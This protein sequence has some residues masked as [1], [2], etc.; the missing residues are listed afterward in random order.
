M[1]LNERQGDILRWIGEGTPERE[2]PDWSHRTTAKAL[3]SRGLVKVR[4]YGP[5]WTATVTDRGRRVLSGEVEVPARGARTATRKNKTTSKS[6]RNATPAGPAQRE[7]L[8]PEDLVADLLIAAD[9][10]LHVPD[11][12]D[13]TRAAYRRALAGIPADLVQTGKRVTYT[14]RNRGDL[15]ISPVDVPNPLPPDPAVVVPS[16]S[17][18]DDL[19]ARREVGVQRQAGA[20]DPRALGHTGLG[21]PQTLDAGIPSP[22]VRPNDREGDPAE[23]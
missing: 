4:G 20:A 14:G 1:G 6:E 23:N 12:D 10:R 2:R 8:D 16:Q 13:A 11:P 18:E 17:D 19:D 21:R 15:I 7:V 5:T 3:Q 9:H 22:W